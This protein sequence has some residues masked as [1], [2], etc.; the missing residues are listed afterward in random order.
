MHI[1]HVGNMANDGFACVE[2]LRGAGVDA[3]LLIDER[4]FGMGLPQWEIYRL[5]GDPYNMN[6]DELPPPPSW[7][8][9]WRS[10]PKNFLRQ[11]TEANRLIDGYDLLHLHYPTFLYLAYTKTPY[12]IYE[13]GFIRQN[14]GK[15]SNS[16]RVKL[17]MHSYRS[18][19]GVTYNNTDNSWMVQSSGAKRI[20]FIPFAI[21]TDRYSPIKKPSNPV[22]EFLHPARMVFDVKGNDRMLRAFVKYI[23]SGKKAKL[24]LVDWGYSEDAEEAHRI[25]EPVKEWV[26][27]VQPMSKP[28]LIDAYRRS[29]AVLDQ[30]TLGGSGTTG[31]EAMSCGTPLM[32]YYKESGT[33][34]F[35]EN[36]PCVNASTEEEILAGFEALES[37]TL[38]SH[39]RGAGRT[40]AEKHLSYPVVARELIKFYKECIG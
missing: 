12:I 22:L 6:I 2:A 31:F 32:I 3:E 10:S 35:G 15:Y 40:F 24:I 19:R 7:V 21:N 17:G 23:Q 5:Q 13:A 36:P 26:K 25:V 8:K 34:H 30:F 33:E 29:D 28:D 14:Y 18:A 4:D 39:L 38:R 11:V 37:D 16:N 27:W 20:R 9:T 1:L